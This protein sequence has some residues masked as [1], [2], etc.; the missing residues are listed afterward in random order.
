MNTCPHCN[1]RVSPLRLLFI[2][3]HYHCGRCGGLARVSEKQSLVIPAV[4][5]AVIFP[6]ILLLPREWSIWTAAGLFVVLSISYVLAI[7]FF[8]RFEPAER[9]DSR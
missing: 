5:S 6:F 2:G 8:V 4:Y 9:S 3:R 7:C 1:A